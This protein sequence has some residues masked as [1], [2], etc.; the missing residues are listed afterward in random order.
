M[1]LRLNCHF[2]LSWI[3]CILNMSIN[4]S[5]NVVLFLHQRKFVASWTSV[6]RI[7][8]Q[9]VSWPPPFPSALFYVSTDDFMILN[10]SDCVIPSASCV[11]QRPPLFLQD[12]SFLPFLIGI[13]TA[14]HLPR[15]SMI[16]S[17]V[18]WVNFAYCTNIYDPRKRSVFS[19]AWICKTI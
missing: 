17:N 16:F 9:N 12:S 11:F 6:R 19:K 2:S 13:V 8:F 15:R 18:S 14:Y 5:A 3:F 10:L 1:V 4:L 7:A